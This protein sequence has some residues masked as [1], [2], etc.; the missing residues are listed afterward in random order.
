MC[1]NKLVPAGNF[2]PNPDCRD[3]GEVNASN[4]IRYGHTEKGVQRDLCK[5]C[6]QTFVETK[7]TLFYR[8]RKPRKDTL[9]ALAMLAERMSIA[10][11]ARVKGVKE[12][13]VS[14]WLC[15]AAEHAKEVEDALLSEYHVESAQ[16]DALWTYVGH[17]GEKGGIQRARRQALSGEGR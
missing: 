17:K 8:K 2:C 9:E 10:S 1:Q 14:R 16:V 12:E 6:K 13:T 4:L 7:G 5:T 11:V 15:E 3:Y